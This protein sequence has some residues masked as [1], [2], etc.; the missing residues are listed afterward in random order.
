MKWLVLVAA[1]MLGPVAHAESAGWT[2]TQLMAVLHNVPSATAHFEERHELADLKV[3]LVSMGTLVYVAPDQLQKV[4]L[5]PIPSRMTVI[6]DRLTI[7]QAGDATRIMSVSGTPELGALVAGI[8]STLAGDLAGL[9]RYYI[10]ALSG[11]SS[12]WVLRLVPR[13]LGM[14]EMVSEIRIGGVQGQLA[15]VETSQPDGDRIVMIITT[16]PT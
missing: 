13:D 1:L 5:T 16:D 12:S 3:P 7:E 2:V 8:R 6:G 4:T 11:K 15:R 10:V 9:N 14:R